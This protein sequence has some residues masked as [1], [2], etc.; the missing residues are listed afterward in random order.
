MEAKSR[1]NADFLLRCAV[2]FVLLLPVLLLRVVT[3]DNELKYLQIADEALRDGHFWCLYHQGAVYADKPPLYLWIIMLFRTVFG[4]HCLFLLEM[5]SLIPAF[6]TLRVLEK[7]CGDALTG[8]FRCAA[9]LALMTSVYFLGGSVVLR[10]DMLMTMFITLALWTFW[11]MFRGDG[12][13]RLKIL[14]PIYVFLAI[15]SKGPVGIMIP[16][17][18]IPAYLLCVR[19][20]DFF[21]KVWGWRTWLILIVL[22]AAWWIPVYLEGGPDYLNNLLFHQ[23]AGR[24]VNAFHHK[25]PVWYYLY[26][27]WYAMGPWSLLTIGV[28]VAALVRRMHFDDLPKFLLVVSAVFFVIMSLVSGKLAIYLLPVFGFINHGAFMVLQRMA[29]EGRGSTAGILCNIAVYGSLAILAAA[30]VIGLFFTGWM[31]SLLA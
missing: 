24:A 3:P 2:V 13:L 29:G 5:F 15:F 7:W 1:L 17:L 20:L 10:M 18:C 16:L 26:T 12:S 11:R 19:R 31:N 22:C 8:R 28:V 30:F 9:F 14:F 6:V 27:I 4:K 23:T 21:K 25:Q